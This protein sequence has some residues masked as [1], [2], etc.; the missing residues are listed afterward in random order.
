MNDKKTSVHIS[1]KIFYY[2]T[3]IE[4]EKQGVLESFNVKVIKT[5]NPNPKTFNWGKYYRETLDKIASAK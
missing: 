2:S 1:N 3:S 5:D 4:P